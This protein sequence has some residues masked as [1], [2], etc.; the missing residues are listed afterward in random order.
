MAL[1]H[2]LLVGESDNRRP[3]GGRCT[4][5][6]DSVAGGIGWCCA[7]DEYAGVGCGVDCG[8]EWCVGGFDD[9]AACGADYF[10]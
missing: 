10:G 8:V 4:C 2:A 5:S 7:V 9:R 1:T 6:W 3:L